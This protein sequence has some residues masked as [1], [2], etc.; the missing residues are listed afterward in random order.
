MTLTTEKAVEQMKS[1]YT[2]INNYSSSKQSEKILDIIEKLENRKMMI[3]FAGHFSAGK[4]TLINTLLNKEMLPSSPIPTSA[5]IVQLNSGESE[6]VVYFREEP[7]VRYE[8]EIE[9]DR[10]QSLFKDGE[11]IKRVDISHPESGLPSHVIV[12]DT[13]GVDSTNDADRLITESSLHLMDHMYYVMDY[14]HVQSEVNLQFLWEMQ[15]RGTPFSI[16]INQIDKHNESEISFDK[17]SQSIDDSFNQWGIAPE[18]IYYTS[19]KDFDLSI[20][21]FEDLKVDFKSLFERSYEVIENQAKLDAESVIQE[22][23]KEAEEDFYQEKQEL[24]E[25]R[26][27]LETLLENSHLSVEDQVTTEELLQKLHDDVQVRIRQF[28]P[29]AYLMPSVLREDAKEFL[30]AQQPGFKV[31]FL[32]SK[33]KTDEEREARNQKFYQHLD[34]VIEKNLKWPLRDRWLELAEKHKVTDESLLKKIQDFPFEYNKDRLHDLVEKGAEVTGD[35]V[36]RY[37]D[38][39]SNDVKKEVRRFTQ[40]IQEQL[41]QT[42]K[43]YQQTDY[44]KHQKA[45]DALEE[46]GQIEKTLEQFSIRIKSYQE[47]LYERLRTPASHMD[48][49]VVKDD[50]KK[51]KDCVLT[52][53]ELPP[54][55][56]AVVNPDRGATEPTNSS[57]PDQSID[58]ILEKVD[59]TLS[60]VGNVQGLDS[61]ID[62]LKGKK[63][64]LK[65]RHYTVALFGA[66]SAGK[67]SFANALLGE[68]VLPV[69]PN[70][71]T[72]TINK[73]SPPTDECP[74]RTIHVAVKTESQMLHD[75]SGILQR[76]GVEVS[77]LRDVHETLLA[78]PEGDREALDHKQLSFLQ[79]FLDGFE[80]MHLY[81]NQSI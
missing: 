27:D 11:E 28:I 69:S 80:E 30:E 76:L 81:M 78:L 20:N 7:P 66:F 12:L 64:R 35:Y 15:R 43:E 21:T 32:F 55:K 65:N 3:G 48:I 50:L 70:P 47:D 24:L 71:T 16:V 68:R 56:K 25:R 39:V 51:R 23:L 46:C 10:L 67:S 75:L 74:D 6:T 38:Q 73:I 79:A 52:S 37:T 5:N 14:N 34:D 9:F 49:Q 13:P 36:L 29:N 42:L 26:K 72:A 44:D 58:S 41:E 59:E 62:Q 8:G 31:G 63:E 17:F 18:R 60:I 57:T 1:L 22:C 33:K 61:L 54:E 53:S 19:M 77:R 2:Y 45:Y 40:N 4:S